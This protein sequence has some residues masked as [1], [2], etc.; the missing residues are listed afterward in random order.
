VGTAKPERLLEDI[1]CML[2][3]YVDLIGVV[4]VVS[5]EHSFALLS[6]APS[7]GFDQGV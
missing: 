4:E 5:T 2:E 6:L 1:R 3:K 7:L